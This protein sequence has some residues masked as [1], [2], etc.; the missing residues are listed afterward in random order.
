M[1][2]MRFN[3]NEINNEYNINKRMIHESKQ[4]ERDRRQQHE[5]KD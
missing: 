4:D 1:I 3:F 5:T 2:I